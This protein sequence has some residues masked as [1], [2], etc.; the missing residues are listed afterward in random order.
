M[1]S[2]SRQIKVFQQEKDLHDFVVDKWIELGQKTIFLQV[3]SHTGLTVGPDGATA[4]CME[5]FAIMRVLPNLIVL[6]P[7]DAIEAKKATRAMAE[8]NGPVYMRVGRAPFPI[9]TKESDPF[10]IGK[11]NVMR[12]GTDVTIIA[13]GLMV[14]ESLKA[15]EALAGEGINA[16]VINMHTIKPIDEEIII[17]S[18]RETKALVTVEEHQVNGGLG[19]AVAEVLAK[20]QPA[21]MEMVAM[22][23][24][25]GESGTPAEL[26][27]KYQLNQT[28]IANAVRKVLKR[29]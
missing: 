27:A 15:A 25:F 16:K 18:A 24:K 8:I 10:E 3:G 21:P 19:S 1:N 26:L 4:Q 6:S 5:D 7:I 9:I 13:N 29:K 23:D 28:G 11:A 12:Q 2:A 22:Q 17:K 14:S 20:H